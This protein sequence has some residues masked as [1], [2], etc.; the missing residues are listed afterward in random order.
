LKRRRLVLAAGGGA[1]L[2]GVAAHLWR[3]GQAP[4]GVP[5]GAAATGS[6]PS[7]WSLT[8]PQPDGTALPLASLLGRPLLVNFWATWCPPC[9]KEM[10]LLDAQVRAHPP[11][12]ALGIAVDERAAVQQFLQRTPVSFPIV[13]AG[14]AGVAMSRELGNAQGG[15][16]YSVLFDASGQVRHRHAGEL[17]EAQLRAL[18]AS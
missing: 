6:Q 15:L 7:L 5:L 11:W 3:A 13:L 17:N 14:F 8:L 16:P 10:P 18:L 9:V 2:A 4:V 1:A 12:Q